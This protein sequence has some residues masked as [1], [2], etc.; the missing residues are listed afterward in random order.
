MSARPPF[1]HPLAPRASVGAEEGGGLSP[2]G[3][4]AFGAGL[5]ATM[6]L[7]VQLVEWMK[8]GRREAERAR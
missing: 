5:L 7:G 4:L 2:S 1:P 8:D 6:F 3:K